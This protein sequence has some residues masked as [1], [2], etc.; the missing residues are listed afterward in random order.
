MKKL[1]FAICSL[2]ALAV[3]AQVWVT[4]PGTSTGAIK[5][6]QGMFYTSGSMSYGV[7]NVVNA[8]MNAYSFGFNNLAGNSN[9]ITIGK[10]NTVFGEAAMSFGS[11]CT[12]G[13][14]SALSAGSLCV[15]SGT[16]AFAQGASAT[17]S[18]SYSH[19]S[20]LQPASPL[21]G[22]LSRGAGVFSTVGDAQMSILTSRITTVGSTPANLLLSGGSS[23]F[24]LIPANT[25]WAF[26][27]LVG[28]RTTDA[29]TGDEE[30]AGYTLQGVIERHNTAATTAIVGVV[31]KVVL[32]EDDVL[33]DV[34]ATADTTNGALTITG[35]GNNE[36]L[37]RWVATI[38]LTQISG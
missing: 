31:L 18:G 5:M 28:A 2:V 32:A 38:T 12:A 4:V 11:G 22:Q 8:G 7:S 26:S 23:T 37:V 16:T 6:M 1:I 15:A 3:A 13:G 20:G 33:W 9:S 34:A 24:I 10:N 29:G 25:T 36:T 19:A 14:T 17:A 27:I 30:S 35:T 21:Y